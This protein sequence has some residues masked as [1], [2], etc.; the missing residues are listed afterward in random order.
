MD[1]ESGV[2][3]VPLASTVPSPAH[4]FG[5]LTIGLHAV[6]LSPVFGNLDGTSAQVRFWIGPDFSPGIS[7]SKSMRLEPLGLGFRT[8]AEVPYNV[9]IEEGYGGRLEFGYT[10]NNHT[11]GGNLCTS[12]V[13]KGQDFSPSISQIIAT[14]L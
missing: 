14:R 11:D 5:G 6:G 13:L 12:L 1:G 4:H 2:F 8:C 10:R 3:F 9:G 7:A